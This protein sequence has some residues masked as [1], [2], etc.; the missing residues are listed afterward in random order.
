M[1]SDDSS[2]PTIVME[3]SHSECSSIVSTESEAEETDYCVLCKK[4][5]HT[6][7]YWGI[8]HVKNA[9]VCQRCVRKHFCSGCRKYEVKHR[10]VQGIKGLNC[11][12]ACYVPK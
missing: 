7:F 12:E 11:C 10:D 3:D 9:P 4:N 2:N 5:K 6:T 8:T 1:D